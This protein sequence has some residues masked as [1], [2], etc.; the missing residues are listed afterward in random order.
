MLCCALY[1]LI[2]TAR[3]VELFRLLLFSSIFGASQRLFFISLLHFPLSLPCS[4]CAMVS[5]ASCVC[6][7]VFEVISRQV[8]SVCVHCYRESSRIRQ[9]PQ[10]GTWHCVLLTL[11]FMSLYFIQIVCNV[12]AV[13]AVL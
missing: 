13:T 11:Y 8:V 7:R 10:V 2:C 3:V 12:C 1:F 9:P 4:S 6:K 5:C